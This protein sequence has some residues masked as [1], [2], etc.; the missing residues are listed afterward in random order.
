MSPFQAFATESPP[1][2]REPR[3]AQIRAGQAWPNTIVRA[4]REVGTR[5]I[6]RTRR[7]DT[8]E[9]G[10]AAAEVSKPEGGAAV[11]EVDPDE[12]GFAPKFRVVEQ[13]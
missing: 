3:S 2:V 1:D 9:V 11:A 5:E 13:S 12:A 7:L 8:V 4:N 10:K 6:Q